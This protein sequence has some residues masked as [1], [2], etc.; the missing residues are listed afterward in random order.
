[1]TLIVITKNFQVLIMGYK[2]FILNILVYQTVGE[3]LYLERL[4]KVR[5]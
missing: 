2:K 1:M 3:E 5:F 4:N